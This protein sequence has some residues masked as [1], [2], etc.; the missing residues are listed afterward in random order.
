[1]AR[2][3]VFPLS[4]ITFSSSASFPQMKLVSQRL[5]VVSAKG[6]RRIAT[7]RRRQD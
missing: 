1:V 3:N 2:L 6:R 5:L 4:T 7:K